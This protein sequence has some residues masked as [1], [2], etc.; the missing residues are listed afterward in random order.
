[1]G[2]VVIVADDCFGDLGIEDGDNFFTVFEA[3]LSGRNDFP[4]RNGKLYPD[5]YLLEE[6]GKDFRTVSGLTVNKVT[7]NELSL[8]QLK[9]KFNADIESM[10]SAA[11]YYVAARNNIPVAGIRSISNYVEQ[12]ERDKWEVDLAINKLANA[13]IH[14]INKLYP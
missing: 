14:I 3:G 7:G 10:E 12:R 9:S 1:M 6:L 13:V 4:F 11:V 5:K 8:A 2:E